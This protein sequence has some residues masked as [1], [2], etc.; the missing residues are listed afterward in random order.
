MPKLT[1]KNFWYATD[2]V[3]SERELQVLDIY[4]TGATSK[5]IGKI[6]CLSPKTIDKHRQNIFEKTKS[7]SP[8]DLLRYAVD[9]NLIDT[10]NWS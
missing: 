3:L 8:M 6:L 5:E 1:S 9:N 10:N 7:R 4:L 2:D